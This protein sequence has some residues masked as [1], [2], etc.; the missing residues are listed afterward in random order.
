MPTPAAQVATSALAAPL[1]DLYEAGKDIFKVQLQKWTNNRNID[2]LAKKVSNYEL[3]KT[4]WR[5]DKPVKLSS[6]YYPSKITFPH[7]AEN[8]KVDSLIDIPKIGCFVVQG[9][10]GQ[11]K[12][13]FL[14]YLC[15]Q[16][17][18][19]QSSKR[20]P[21]FVELKKIDSTHDLKSAL[22]DTISG[23]GFQITEELF[24]Y[25][26]NSGKMVILLDGFDEIKDELTKT[27]ITQLESWILKY[28]N[29]QFII[30]SRPGSEIQKCDKF[31]TILLAPLSPADHE[32]FLKK[33]GLKG[34]SLRNLLKAISESSVEISGLLT[35]PLLLT[36]LVIVYQSEGKIPNELPEFFKLLF[37]T[38]FSRH[39]NSKPGFKR[40]HKSGLNERNLERLFEAFCFSVLARN[41]SVTLKQDQFQI[42]FEDATRFS[43][44]KCNLDDFFHDIGRVACLIQEDGQYFSF[45]HKSLLDYYPA[46]Y[47]KSCSELLAEPLY[48]R[49][50]SRWQHWKATLQFL[51][52]IDKYR[53]I[54][55]IA[56]PEL[57]RCLIPFLDE[58]ENI[59]NASAEK[60]IEK[61]YGNS[62][63]CYYRIDEEINGL[64]RLHRFGPYQP[65]D[66]Y[67]NSSYEERLFLTPEIHSTAPNLP[68]D[69]IVKEIEP[70]GEV[71]YKIS[72]RDA[73]TKDEL[74]KI[75]SQVKSYQQ[76][77]KEKL[78]EFRSYMKSEEDKLNI[79]SIL[80]D[81]ES[82]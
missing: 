73:F 78:D 32:P 53:F 45:V 9:T 21:I 58:N 43:E 56:L 81:H 40:Q 24:E 33:I 47:I 54:K 19:N 27:V 37:S 25:Y 30:T 11:G 5:R 82:L 38:V 46:A 75:K 62:A 68:A 28:P 69:K 10:V 6:F 15:I 48:K 66:C 16:E 72:W 4:L 67:I 63:H 61:V 55:Y 64:F 44:Q 26:A 29:L 80:M 76:K 79:L 2:A 22:F 71:L 74:D 60:Y 59:S 17:L 12:T 7:G 52:Y 77:L 20:I 39:D 65:L 13:T 41:F 34:E 36:L 70:N 1:K 49:I 50:L 23:L 51:E 31:S 35:T 3:V 18:T 14:R 57:N 8:K 42:A